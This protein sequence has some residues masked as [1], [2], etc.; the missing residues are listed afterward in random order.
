[1]PLIVLEGCDGS[2]KSTLAASLKREWE[3]PIAGIAHTGRT[4]AVIHT[5]PPDP[6]DREVLEEYELTLDLM[7]D[8]IM[9]PHELLILDRWHLGDLVYARYRPD[10]QPR[11]TDAAL[12]HLEMALTSLGALKVILSPSLAAVQARIARDGD[13]YIDHGDVPR[14]HAEYTALSQRLG[15]LTPPQHEEP[16]AP[17]RAML[18]WASRLTDTARPFYDASGGTWTGSL[19]PRIIFAGD[20]LGGTTESRA[21]K[22]PF[23]RPFTPVTTNNATST[24]HFFTALLTKPGPYWEDEAPMAREEGVLASW[25]AVYPMRE[26]IALVNVN[27]PGVDIPALAKLAEGAH[28]VALGHRAA[29]TLTLTGIRHVTTWHPSFAR[30][31]HRHDITRYASQLTRAVQPANGIQP[32]AEV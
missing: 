6:H 20:Q 2:G 12:L 16:D 5:G 28:W 26:G 18:S 1:M 23:C 25:D 14:I 19:S 7:A 4:A 17:V 21:A 11:L 27:D 13:D 15:Y 9:S 3:Q 31:F 32:A 22:P 30:R 8:R 24:H 29:N 10:K